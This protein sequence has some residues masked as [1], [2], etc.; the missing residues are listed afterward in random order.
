[1]TCIAP[2][3]QRFKCYRVQSTLRNELYFSYP[4]TDICVIVCLVGRG[5]LNYIITL[6]SLFS[7][8]STYL[9]LVGLLA[10]MAQCGCFVPAEYASFR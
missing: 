3:V 5:R 10:I 9:K 2:T 1:M 7:G 6:Y 8:K 4:T